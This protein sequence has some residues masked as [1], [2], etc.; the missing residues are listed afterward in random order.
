[1]LP[2]R[3][4]ACVLTLIITL[5][6]EALSL[7]KGPISVFY[8]KSSGLFP[9]SWDCS[10]F[11]QCAPAA[12]GFTAIW[13]PCSPG[14]EFDPISNGCSIPKN[15]CANLANV[16]S[17]TCKDNP[18]MV[19]PHPDSCSLYYN[20]TQTTPV[21]GLS[22]YENECTYPTLFDA[23]LLTCS[24]A[25][26]VNCGKRNKP[27]DQCG[28]R[29]ECGRPMCEGVP[30]G[31]NIYPGQPFDVE[32]VVCENGTVTNSTQ[33]C[34]VGVFDP[35]VRVCTTN[36]ATSIIAYCTSTPSAIFSSPTDCAKYIDCS[37]QSHNAKLNPFENECDYPMLFNQVT[38]RCEIYNKV[39]CG[40]RPVPKAPCDYTVGYCVTPT[41]CI[42]CAATCV[43]KTNGKH[44]YP[45]TASTNK[46]IVCQ[47][48][49]TMDVA[50]CTTG[51]IFDPFVAQCAA[52]MSTE[53]LN[54]ICSS[55]PTLKLEHPGE[56]AQYYDCSKTTAFG[57]FRKFVKECYYP[58]LFD[59]N[60]S[61]CKNPSL[62]TCGSRSEPKSLCEY[63]QFQ[64][65]GSNCAPC[66][67][68]LPECPAQDGNAPIRLK[69]MTRDYI[70][71]QGGR[72]VGVDQCAP[73]Q[74]FDMFLKVC[75]TVI[76]KA[77]FLSY[78]TTYPTGRIPNPMHCGQ[79]YDC[80][81]YQQHGDPVPSDCPYPQEFDVHTKRCAPFHITSCGGRV[82]QKEPCSY[83]SMHTCVSPSNPATCTC[84]VPSC[85]NRM[86]GY[87]S[88]LSSD[89]RQ[90]YVCRSQ[91]TLI[92]SCPAGEIFDVKS[93]AC[94]HGTANTPIQVSSFCA[95]NPTGRIGHTDFCHKYFDCSIDPTNTE[96]QYPQLFDIAT[97][98]CV[99]YNQATCDTRAVVK[100]PCEYDYL[101]PPCLPNQRCPPC[102]DVYPSCVG[103]PNTF[104]APVPTEA[105]KYFVCTD[106]RTY[107]YSC[108]TGL[109]YDPALKKCAKPIQYIT[110]A[111]EAAEKCRQ[112]PTA[113]IPKGDSCSQ[114]Y[115]CTKMNS[116]LGAYLDE[117]NYPE[118]FDVTKGTCAAY[119]TVSCGKR[120]EPKSPCEYLNLNF[121]CIP[122]GRPCAACEMSR[123]SCKGR[124]N[125]FKA[126]VDASN[127]IN[128]FEC[129]DERT[130]FKQCQA[131]FIFDLTKLA[132]QSTDSQPSVEP[133]MKVTSEE[134]WEVC[135]V[136]K[137]AMFPKGD[138]C[139]QYF[140]CRSPYSQYGAYVEECS[141][142][143][144]FEKTTKKCAPHNTVNCGLRMEPKKPCEYVANTFNYCEMKTSCAEC[145]ATLPSCVGYPN[146]HG[147]ASKT[148]SSFGFVCQNDRTLTVVCQAGF[149]FSSD[150]GRCKSGS[151]SKVNVSTSAEAVMYCRN[152]PTELVAKADNCAQY[153]DCS[154]SSSPFNEAH[155]RECQY[156][157]YFD[158]AKATCA[159]Y[160][161]VTCSGKSTP[162]AP[163]E[164]R[165]INQI[166]QMGLPCPACEAIQ[167]SCVGKANVF[168][169]PIS[170]DPSKYFECMD[171]RTSI[172]YCRTGTTFNTATLRCAAQTQPDIKITSPAE[173]QPYCAKDNTAM[174]P[175][176]G[177]CAQFFDCS[178]LSR[179]PFQSPYLTECFYPSLYDIPLKKCRH[180]TLVNCMG[181]MEPKASCEYLRVKCPD[182][183]CDPN[184]PCKEPSCVGLPNGH[185]VYPGKEMTETFL[186]CHMERVTGIMTCSANQFFDPL[187]KKCTGSLTQEV[188]NWYCSKFPNTRG[189][190]PLNC[191]HSIDCGAVNQIIECG[192]PNL[193]NG[194]H[195]DSFKNVICGR[196]YEPKAPCEY[197]QNQ[198]C[199]ASMSTCKPCAE[200]IAS[201]VG[202]KDGTN[203]Y[204][205]KPPN[206][207]FVECDSNRTSAIV[208]CT[209]NIYN[210]LQNICGGIL[211]KEYVLDQCAKF[212]T[213]QFP[214]PT[215]CAL[216][217]DCADPTA[218]LIGHKYLKEC[219]H[220]TH[221]STKHKRCMDVTVPAGTNDLHCG[222]RWKPSHKCDYLKNCP[223]PDNCPQCTNPVP[224][225]VNKADGYYGSPD[226]DPTPVTWYYC[227][228]GTTT[229]SG[230]CSAGKYFDRKRGCVAKTV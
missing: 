162:K 108:S 100:S 1:M 191:A 139:A 91:R 81:T 25:T 18:T 143:E 208:Q 187:R 38:K 23:D 225:C 95:R 197:E 180:F 128:Y 7:V 103:K 53:S 124:L 201:C 106:E 226:N 4:W 6:R 150:I 207:L 228:S 119:N 30:D 31:M 216:Y 22:K 211:T 189:Y 113:I 117:C 163:C 203:P 83:K 59:P 26:N 88:V 19:F 85:V 64:C 72:I 121:D 194:T 166:C 222:T 42:D 50:I 75:T 219:P 138:N 164:Y 27:L 133:G 76:G 145:E 220:P 193:F 45:G 171:E 69:E 79:Y 230:D 40:T 160:S 182:G 84:N 174:Y 57:N 198:H 62:V 107:I 173:A 16:A 146:G 125:G 34:K 120:P 170:A 61:T 134:A 46:Y 97:R 2:S 87:T 93:G 192:Y 11:V 15:R 215:N 58:F 109:V 141:Y 204:P 98:K 127:K 137:T 186:E 94:I 172:Q 200:R 176:A 112:Q 92:S 17:V 65:V 158:E 32:Y 49:R 35:I 51:Q 199:P 90:F 115:D 178:L 213:E 74:I 224:S 47:D 144:L 136:D 55:N 44:T 188:I 116:L 205:G 154:S 175:H 71:C 126:L 78:C 122:R 33:T 101:V 155:L 102:T 37:A 9:L 183:I 152:H 41:S 218:S 56:C 114:F 156:P 63:L 96:C 148:N 212:P 147:L 223:T 151:T 190:Q 66:S 99:P 43:G 161:S 195:C 67:D 110:T 131:G 177:N 130:F 77:A 39:N 104:K 29:L 89:K 70:I 36:Y 214:D 140:D 14:L 159:V 202:L 184:K 142:S 217:Y 105:T 20:C 86:E 80:A 165:S 82:E 169:G 123:P 196:R 54:S 229:A 111:T 118:L 167:P 206:P 24:T 185:N 28:Y 12:D 135:R 13:M 132:C 149:I 129:R 153:Y 210:P 52:E 10:G 168:K 221:Y 60:D 157:A 21:D 181:R 8:C 73:G 179:G 209:N 5:T 68:V 227:V 3:F 48:E